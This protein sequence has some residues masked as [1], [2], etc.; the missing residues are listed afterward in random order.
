MRPASTVARRSYGIIEPST[1][2]IVSKKEAG[3]GEVVKTTVNK[4]VA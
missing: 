4:L 1:K 2:R 3:T